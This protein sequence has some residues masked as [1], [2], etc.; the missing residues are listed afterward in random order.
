MHGG[1][2]EEA[3][4]RARAKATAEVRQLRA[5]ALTLRRCRGVKWERFCEGGGGLRFKGQSE[6]FHAFKLMEY[7]SLC[8]V[9]GWVDGRWQPAVG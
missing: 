1:S 9:G 2:S 5:K 8:G 4:A 3:K 7:V 6:T